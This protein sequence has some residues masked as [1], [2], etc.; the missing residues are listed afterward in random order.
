MNGARSTISFL[1]LLLL[2]I[3]TGLGC[4]KQLKEL[5]NDPDQPADASIPKLFTRLLD[6]GRVRPNYWEIRTFVALHTGVYSQ[7]LGYL[8]QL[9]AYQQNASY[10][11]DRWSDFYRSSPNGAGIMVHYR[12]M[13]KAWQELDQ[14]EEKRQQEVFLMA[15]R[16]ITIDMATQ[17]VDLW[18]DIPFFEAGTLG[19][20]G[21]LTYSRFDKAEDIYTYALDQ[22]RNLAEYFSSMVLNSITQSS[23]NQQD[24]LLRGDLQRWRRYA[25]ALRLRLWMRLSDY[26]PDAARTA[27]LEMLQNPSVFPLPDGS[28]NYNPAYD[29]ILLQPLTNYQENLF[30]ALTEL[31]NFSAPHYMLDSV[32]KPANDPRIP[33]MFDKYGRLINGSFVPN[34]DYRGLPVNIIASEQ[35]PIMGDYATLD[36]ATFLFNSKLP[37]IHFSSAEVNF[38][39]AEAFTRWGGGDAKAHYERAVRQSIQFYYYLNSLNTVTRPP[40]TPPT[41]IAIDA[42]LQNPS[43]N[44]DAEPTQRLKK[45]ITQKWLHFGFLQSVQAWSEYRR[46]GYPAL[47]FLR[48]P[49]SGFEF[50]PLRL[51]Y[52]SAETD[53]NPH[54]SEVKENDLRDRKIFW[55]MR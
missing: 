15:A 37:G 36:S 26:S 19:A 3:T 28:S 17:M 18:G 31:N 54:Y 32:M 2:L 22:L 11:S 25:N 51:T 16:L 23:F 27:V 34:S 5:Y 24:I 44:L 12:A 14:P 45:I 1:F 10:S 4:R 30:L 9:T 33:V 42:F 47:D 40:L 21:I 49:R 6:N 7:T 20:N 35:Q 55:Q 52:P 53:Y 29:D 13:E 43:I 38:L 46:T 8:N 50:P 48:M 39:A 41:E